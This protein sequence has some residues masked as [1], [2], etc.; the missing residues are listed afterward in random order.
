MFENDEET[1]KRNKQINDQSIVR[2]DNRLIN[3]RWRMNINQSRIFLAGISMIQD[4]DDENET[5]YINHNQLKTLIDRKGNSLY[6][7]LRRDVP[8]LMGKVIEVERPDGKKDWI[9][10]GSASYV[11]GELRLRFSREIRPYLMGLK[12]QFTQFKLSEAIRFKSSYTLRIFMLLKQFDKKGW[13]W[14]E[15]EEL[16][17]ILDINKTHQNQLKKDLYV[18]INDLKKR[19]IDPSVAELNE[20]G[21]KVTYEAI[22]EGRKIVAF[23]FSWKGSIDVDVVEFN[24]VDQKAQ[25]LLERLKTLRLNDRQ[26]KYLGSLVGKGIT[27]QDLQQTVWAIEKA[28]REKNIPKE[29]HGGYTYATFSKKFGISNW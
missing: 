10:M 29:K 1:Q 8:K 18:K 24:P 26:I 17:N 21:F 13:R 20:S 27:N 22:K 11:D 5:Y 9:Q 6:D 4:S 12:E 15:I 19:V 14:M 23:K 25:R 16:R 2:Q 28:I 7:D 3:G